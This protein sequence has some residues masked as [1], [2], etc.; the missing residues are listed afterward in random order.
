VN[1]KT[2][3]LAAAAVAVMGA[4]SAYAAVVP[5][6][7]GTDVTGF[8]LSDGSLD[9]N[10]N[11]PNVELTNGDDYVLDMAFNLQN[12]TAIR[13]DPLI[14]ES[15][16][17]TVK[18]FANP[19]AN[20]GIGVAQILLTA[21]QPL[22]GGSFVT[23]QWGDGPTVALSSTGAFSSVRTSFSKVGGSSNI[24]E[25]VFAWDLKSTQQLSANIA[26]VPLPA[27]L[28]LM[29]TALGGLGLARRRRNK[30]AAA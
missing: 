26:P 5:L 17:L 4:T 25:L 9:L 12:Y 13:I 2:T 7:F 21:G 22:Q 8:T 6:T 19:F 28:L 23:A 16:T 30:K 3:I 20:G 18:T 14:S 1:F 29:S 15:G 10:F 24:Q 27:G 11:A